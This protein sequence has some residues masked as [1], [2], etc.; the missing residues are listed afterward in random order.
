MGR[1]DVSA[2]GCYRGE[3]SSPGNLST[4]SVSAVVGRKLGK[5]A[6]PVGFQRNA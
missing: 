2:A 3:T 5:L 1:L 4:L 6:L